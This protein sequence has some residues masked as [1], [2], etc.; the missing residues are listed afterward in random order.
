MPRL[1]D[2]QAKL[3]DFWPST[4]VQGEHEQCEN[5]WS[6]YWSFWPGSEG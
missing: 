4:S 3:V 5:S 1:A 6:P 2:E